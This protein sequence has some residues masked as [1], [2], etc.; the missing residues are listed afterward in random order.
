MVTYTPIASK[1]EATT[2][3]SFLYGETA[4]GAVVKAASGAVNVRDYGAVGDGVANDTAAIQ[5]AIDAG[6]GVF[7]PDGTYKTTALLT[8]DG[9]QTFRGESIT[10]TKFLVDTPSFLLVGDGPN[11]ARSTVE[12]FTV[13]PNQTP[14]NDAYGIKHSVTNYSPLRNSITIKDIVFRGS[15]GVIQSTLGFHKYLWTSNT[16]GG[17]ARNVRIEGGY[18]VTATSVGQFVTIGAHISG[19][20]VGF[21]MD[22]C[23]FNALHTYSLS[24]GTTE[25]TQYAWCE[26]VGCR[27]GL[28][29][30]VPSM[31]PGVW[32]TSCHM[33]TS[34]Y[35]I[36]ADNRAQVNITNCS[37][38]RTGT[39]FAETYNAVAGDSLIGLELVG[40][41]VVNGIASGTSRGVYITNSQFVNVV[42][43]TIRDTQYGIEAAGGNNACNFDNI[44]FNSVDYPYKT[45]ATDTRTFLGQHQVNGTTI[46][47]Y[48]LGAQGMTVG[49]QS[50][51]ARLGKVVGNATVSSAGT[52]ELDIV[53]NQQVQRCGFSA[54]GGPYTY[55]I[56]LLTDGVLNGD[57]FEIYVNLPSSTNPSVVF[58]NGAGGATL[59][60]L[61]VA[62]STKYNCRFV[63]ADTWVAQQICVS[64]V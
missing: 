53:N 42:G 16:Y 10:G 26:G 37:L 52:L 41:E 39:F 19:Q 54:G 20:S 18:I 47:R 46:T 6:R 38:Y 56:D 28:D 21:L 61:N 32:I 45:D 48:T 60:T 64:I 4:A 2:G 30:S 13:L 51:R 15:D 5:A 9:G 14:T 59:A 27:D 62:S 63:Y 31:K 12:T 1:A 24:D 58:R 43:M 36:R 57:F 49:V 22:H 23:N 29:V 25:G 3:V 7:I 50:N 40:N 17:E 55:N 44:V 34:R 33:N 35:G 8:M 11:Y